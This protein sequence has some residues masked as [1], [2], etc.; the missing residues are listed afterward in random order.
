MALSAL[1]ICLPALGM[2]KPDPDTNKR[3]C[4]QKVQTAHKKRKQEKPQQLLPP[5]E[6]TMTTSTIIDPLLVVYCWVPREY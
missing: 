2:Q 5:L 3:N 1:I 4:Q 6:T